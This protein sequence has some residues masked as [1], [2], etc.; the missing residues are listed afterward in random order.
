MQ[1]ES[2][3]TLADNSIKSLGKWY[4]ASLKDFGQVQE[5]VSQ[6]KNWFIVL[7]KTTLPGKLKVWCYQFGI[8][9]R[10]NWPFALY[11]FPLTVVER[12]ERTASKYLRKWLGVPR[13]FS[14][15]NLYT[16]TSPASLPT[17]SITEEFKVSQARTVMLMRDSRDTVK[18]G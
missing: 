13:S 18:R 14:S 2:I 7:D 5:T 11:D 6:L 16:T 1:G 12:M 8:V 17:T 4:N 15:V 10:L 3:P 9:P